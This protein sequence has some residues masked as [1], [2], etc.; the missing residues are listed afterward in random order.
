MGNHP[1][2]RKTLWGQR[3]FSESIGVERWRAM[4]LYNWMVLQINCH[5]KCNA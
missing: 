1:A 5:I 2:V 4:G 3:P